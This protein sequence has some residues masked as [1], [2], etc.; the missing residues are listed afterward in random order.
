MIGLWRSRSPSPSSSSSSTTT[1]TT[2]T[3]THPDA[4]C[5]RP[6]THE[7]QDHATTTTSAAPLPAATPSSALAAPPKPTTTK[8]IF[9]FLLDSDPLLHFDIDTNTNSSTASSNSSAETDLLLV[10]GFGLNLEHHQ[11]WM[12]S[13]IDQQDVLYPSTPSTTATSSACSRDKSLKPAALCCDWD[14]LA[15]TDALLEE[16]TAATAHTNTL[17]FTTE[18]DLPM[19]NN[20]SSSHSHPVTTS[21]LA[22]PTSTTTSAHFL[23]GLGE[24]HL[25]HDALEVPA[26]ATHANIANVDDLTLHQHYHYGE[27]GH[28]SDTHPHHPRQHHYRQHDPLP[29]PEH[30]PHHHEQQQPSMAPR[31]RETTLSLEEIAQSMGLSMDIFPTEHTQQQHQSQMAAGGRHPAS[32]ST[33]YHGQRHSAPAAGTV[34]STDLFSAEHGAHL[35]SDAYGQRRHQQHQQHQHLLQHSHQSQPKPYSPHHSQQD[36]TPHHSSIKAEPSDLDTHSNHLSASSTPRLLPL[37]LA[38]SDPLSPAASS[39]VPSGTSPIL[40]SPAHQV[41]VPISDEELRASSSSAS[42]SSLKKKQQRKRAVSTSAKPRRVSLSSP[43][44]SSL[45]QATSIAQAKPTTGN[46]G[47]SS[48]SSSSSSKGRRRRLSKDEVVAKRRTRN[49]LKSV[50]YRQRKRQRLEDL[51]NKS[52]ILHEACK[53]AFT[54]L[55]ERLG[56]MQQVERATQDFVAANERLYLQA[57]PSPYRRRPVTT[58]LDNIDPRTLSKDEREKLIKERNRLSS[59]G[60]REEKKREIQAWE[61][62]YATMVQRTEVLNTVLARYGMAEIS[63]EALEEP[64]GGE[65]QGSSDE[66]DSNT[67]SPHTLSSSVGA[68]E[69]LPRS[70]SLP[71]SPTGAFPHMGAPGPHSVVTSPSLRRATEAVSLGGG[72]TTAFPFAPLDLAFDSSHAHHHMAHHSQSPPHPPSSSS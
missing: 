9:P 38:G 52:T 53:Q 66:Q 48:S 30:L 37:P 31:A 21:S 68:Q 15:T 59:K 65:G 34:Q 61:T 2:T 33:S 43:A 72:T 45:A 46:T 18:H 24:Q 71:Q 20:N 7:T 12:P 49:R 58:P 64:T 50:R 56:R 60:Y 57:F 32:S 14:I 4:A 35:H 36:P 51:K 62:F 55:L 47:S 11:Q 41:T 26:S 27:P 25:A 63:G 29:A 54:A 40:L 5:A 16:P 67:N 28:D 70:T 23:L 1:T 69:S 6:R 10:D 17:N 22:F 44:S 19:D 39:H 42:R 13:D 8:P 3:T